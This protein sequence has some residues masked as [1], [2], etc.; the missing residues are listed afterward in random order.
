MTVPDGIGEIAGALEA[1]AL[2]DP[3]DAR[4]RN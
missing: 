3:Y 2:G 4:S 1:D